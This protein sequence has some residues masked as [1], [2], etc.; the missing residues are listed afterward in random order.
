MRNET[1]YMLGVVSALFAVNFLLRALPFVLFA[2]R[3][4]KLP[5]W[6]EKLG[7]IVSPVVIFSLIVY[8]YAGL[9]WRSAWPYVAG[10]VTVAVYL[11]FKNSLAGILSGTVLYMAL[12]SLFGGCV[13][14]SSDEL[15]SKA[16]RPIIKVTPRGIKFLDRFV[17]PDDVPRLLRKHNVSKTK[18]LHVYV[19]PDFSDRRALWVF[20]HNYLTRHGYSKSVW[21]GTRTGVSGD[22]TI[23]P[24]SKGRKGNWNHDGR[25]IRR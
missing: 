8:S 24:D 22:S 2:G 21:V 5:A 16:D 1:L 11:V 14:V 10:A 20:K 7:E 23:I 17:E 18:T 9:E 13:S 19:D 25:R 4:R 6:A 3:T 12:L 15:L